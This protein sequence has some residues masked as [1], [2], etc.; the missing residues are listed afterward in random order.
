[1][2]AQTAE[3]GRQTRHI[4]TIRETLNTNAIDLLGTM[5]RQRDRGRS[6]LVAWAELTGED[7][8]DSVVE[9]GP[10][11]VVRDGPERYRAE[12]GRDG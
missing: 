10:G 2:H 5:S 11:G 9:D 12:G 3:Y 1:V 7:V 4:A 6:R 8:P